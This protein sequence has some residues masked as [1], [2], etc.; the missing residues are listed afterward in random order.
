MSWPSASCLLAEEPLLRSLLLVLP[1]PE[2]DAELL[3]GAA[4]LALSP[5]CTVLLADGG[6]LISADNTCVSSKR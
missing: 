2:P 4:D 6:D 3:T 1:L 5:F